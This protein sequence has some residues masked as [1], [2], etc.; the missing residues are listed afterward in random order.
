MFAYSGHFPCPDCPLSVLGPTVKVKLNFSP[1]MFCRPE[2]SLGWPEVLSSITD[3][4]S[5]SLG[6]L[7]YANLALPGIPV[8]N[9]GP[10]FTWT[11][12]E[13]TKM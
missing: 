9:K 6:G 3:S 7:P 1:L 8:Y 4:W 10:G 11:R 5:P 2:I 13:I 12:L